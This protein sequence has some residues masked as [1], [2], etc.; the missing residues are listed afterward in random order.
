VPWLSSTLLEVLC[1]HITHLH[2]SCLF[3]GLQLRMCTV[4]L[5]TLQGKEGLCVRW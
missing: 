5:A 4:M 2:K 3:P 1:V